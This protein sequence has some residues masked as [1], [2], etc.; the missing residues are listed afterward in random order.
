MTAPGLRAL[1]TATLILAGM[2]F[3][4]GL[5][6]PIVEFS[7]LWLFDDA[8]SILSLVGALAGAGE[9]LLAA[10]V[11]AFA[12]VFP[13]AKILLLGVILGRLPDVSGRSRTVTAL[14][15]IGKWS[16]LDVLV[17]AVLIVAVKVGGIQSAATQPGIYVFVAAIVLSFA[18]N[19]MVSRLL[20]RQEI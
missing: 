15:I 4:A 5:I 2:C 18:G 14:E 7:R 17:A 13:A 9:W 19:R 11:S 10:I 8:Y 16:M 12:V 20:V 6:L 3:S 1:T